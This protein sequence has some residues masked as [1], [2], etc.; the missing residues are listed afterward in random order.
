MKR[1]REPECKMRLGGDAHLL[2]ARSH[3]RLR[4][5]QGG[6]T[7]FGDHRSK[8]GRVSVGVDIRPEWPLRSNSLSFLR[9]MPRPAAPRPRSTSSIHSVAPRALCP[10]TC[11]AGCEQHAPEAPRELTPH[12]SPA[13]APLFLLTESRSLPPPIIPIS[14]SHYAP[15]SQTLGRSRDDDDDGSDTG[16]PCGTARRCS[17]GESAP[18]IADGRG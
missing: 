13:P 17:H 15:C 12:R 11:Y 14:I 7:A 5:H 10:D 4:R 2:A 9:D 3:Q 8:Q 18:H 16:S 6:G 1:K